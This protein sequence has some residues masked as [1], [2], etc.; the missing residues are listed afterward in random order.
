MSKSEITILVISVIGTLF[1]TLIPITALMWRI[2]QI[3]ARD[4]HTDE[5]QL[6]NLNGLK[7]RIEHIGTRLNGQT[8]NLNRRLKNVERFL[9]KTTEFEER[10]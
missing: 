7:E 4:K 10:E 8:E 9:A 6:L 1:T 5:I 3:V 2:F